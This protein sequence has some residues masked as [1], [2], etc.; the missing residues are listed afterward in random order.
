M[1]E[2]RIKLL[3]KELTFLKDIFM[4]HAGSAHGIT[5][6]DMEIQGL[7]EDDEVSKI[8]LRASKFV[9]TLVFSG[10]DERLGVLKI[11]F[12]YYRNYCITPRPGWLR[13][14]SCNN[15]VLPGTMGPGTAG[16]GEATYVSLDSYSRAGPREYN[17]GC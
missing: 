15:S 8:L 1:L 9:L 10:S 11:A 4:A 7:L 14:C 2:E 5:V 3:A 13:I 16:Q 6:D 12:N 17:F